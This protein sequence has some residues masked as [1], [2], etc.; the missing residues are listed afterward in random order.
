MCLVL[1]WLILYIY[2]LFLSTTGV[3]S[4][5]LSHWRSSFLLFF[6]WL[7]L[8][9]LLHSSSFISFSIA[10]ISAADSQHSCEQTGAQKSEHP[11]LQVPV[12]ECPDAADTD[13]PEG[14]SGDAFDNAGCN[15][16]LDTEATEDEGDCAFVDSEG[17]GLPGSVAPSWIDL[18]GEL[19]QFSEQ[20]GSHSSEQGDVHADGVLALP[21]TAGT[22]VGGDWAGWK[23]QHSFRQEGAHD[24]GQGFPQVWVCKSCG[25]VAPTDDEEIGKVRWIGGIS[26]TFASGGKLGGIIV[27]PQQAC[28]QTWVQEVEHWEGHDDWEGFTTAFDADFAEQQAGGQDGEHIEL[29]EAVHSAACGGGEVDGF[30]IVSVKWLISL[31]PV[32]QLVEHK[33]AHVEGQY[34][35]IPHMCSFPIC[36]A[37]C[38]CIS[39]FAWV[40]ITS[41]KQH[42]GVQDGAHEL[43]QPKGHVCG[44]GTWIDIGSTDTWSGWIWGWGKFAL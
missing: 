25:D 30:G 28:G 24:W 11:D 16:V 43:E 36:W 44:T 7:H 2:Y 20:V 40:F 32:Q 8:G 34:G 37:L 19:Q 4:F 33:G 41:G 22:G 5:L 26:I 18:I 42:W 9:S 12:E 10:S 21:D 31:F 3:I 29:H 6:S 14:D 38:G 35:I 39:L 27:L 17:N 1:R 15:D 23:V 13:V